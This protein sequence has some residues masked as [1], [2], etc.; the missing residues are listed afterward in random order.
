MESGRRGEA[1]KKKKNP[2]I[3]TGRGVFV[4]IEKKTGGATTIVRQE[5]APDAGKRAR[6]F[7]LTV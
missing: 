1:A 3:K 7:L 2:Q 4:T 5:R 6:Y